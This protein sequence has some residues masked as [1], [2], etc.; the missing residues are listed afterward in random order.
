MLTGV[1]SAKEIISSR[2]FKNLIGRAV[3]SGKYSEGSILV[4]D[5]S[6]DKNGV[7]NKYVDLFNEVNNEPCESAILALIRN[8]CLDTYRNDGLY[9]LEYIVNNLNSSTLESDLTDYFMRLGLS[10]GEARS[11]VRNKLSSLSAI[12][13]FIARFMVSDDNAFEVSSLSTATYAF[14]SSDDSEEVRDSLKK[15][16]ESIRKSLDSPAKRPWLSI[17]AKTQMGIRETDAL[18]AW[19]VSEESQAFA[20]APDS[21][22]GIEC[23]CGAFSHISFHEMMRIDASQLAQLVMHWISGKSTNEIVRALNTFNGFDSKKSTTIW[24]IDK[25]INSDISYSLSNFVSCILDIAETDGSLGD[26]Y[27]SEE[28]RLMHRRLKYGVMNQFECFFCEMVIDDRM[29]AAQIS[30][31]LHISNCSDDTMMRSILQ[32]FA[33]DVRSLLSEYPKYC[34]ER[35][36]EYMRQ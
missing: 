25:I 8:V 9:V 33:G 17:Y 22:A 24:K 7:L 15:L 29:I 12:E 13:T 27:N 23:L 10:E 28:L 36:N 5:A 34:I 3:R 20:N 2:D 16:F 35:F 31:K 4:V 14:A 6:T 11:A 32:I 21:F 18:H 26:R 1:Y 30:D 19:C